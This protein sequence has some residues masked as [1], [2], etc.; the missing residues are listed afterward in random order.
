MRRD[1]LRLPRMTLKGLLVAAAAAAVAIGLVLP[2]P[3]RSQN[4]PRQSQFATYDLGH[5]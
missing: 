2:L 1:R 4:A 3:H 5:G